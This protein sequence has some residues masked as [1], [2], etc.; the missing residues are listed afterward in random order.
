MLTEKNRYDLNH[1]NRTAHETGL[2]DILAKVEAGMV[3]GD[4]FYVDKTNGLDTGSYDGH[5][6]GAA[7]KTFTYALTKCGDYD[8]IIA[9]PGVYDEGAVLNITQKGLKIIGSNTTGH[10]WGT[11]SLKA[12][13]AD[14]TILTINANE[15]EIANLSFIQNNANKIIAVG[16]TA[17]TYKT[18]IHD[19]FFGGGQ[20]IGS[21]TA[22]IGIDM[23]V[24]QDAPDCIVER[25]NF[26][27]CVIGVQM[28][29]TR[30]AVIDCVFY[31]DGS[32]KGISYLNDASARASN[33]ILNNKFYTNDSTNANAIVVENTP[34]AGLLF[35]DGN[36]FANFA[37][38]IKCISKT[39]G[40]I[41]ANDYG[42]CKKNKTY[43]VCGSDGSNTYD[44]LSPDRP[45]ATLTYALTIAGNYDTIVI[46]PKST[47]DAAASYTITQTGL[48]IT[49]NNKS[50]FNHNALVTLAATASPIFIIAAHEVEITNLGITQQSASSCIQLGSA[51]GQSWAKLVIKGCRF[52]GWSTATSCISRVN[53]NVDCP[54]MT[55]EN[56]F[57]KSFA[58]PVLEVNDTRSIIR[59]NIIKVAAT[60]AAITISSTAGDRGDNV[61]CGNRIVGVNSTDTG[62]LISGT[63]DAGKLMV[64]D[65]YIFNCATTI[66]QASTN[67]AVWRNYANGADASAEIDSIA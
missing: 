39:K 60:F 51:A 37:T 25:C 43:Y 26:Y 14:H 7:F 55:I 67:K 46:S 47:L 12:S 41:G 56:C 64:W 11:T 58:G 2:G 31:V 63:P 35:I 10:M 48:K 50:E 52:D 54:D 40:Y 61:I 57:F 59:N 45:F 5:T 65:N 1:M 20:S 49:G 36:T 44:G 23:G 29:G 38:E 66:T 28:Y 33:R 21:S 17:A 3:T 24:A 30:C 42:T 13:A 6:W 19:C 4:I 15:V 22:T 8:T 27:M 16:T 34:T 32:D 53:A 62:I 9:A 18:H